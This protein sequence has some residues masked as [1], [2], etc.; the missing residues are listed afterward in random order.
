MTVAPSNHMAAFANKNST[1]VRTERSMAARRM[2]SSLAVALVL[3]VSIDLMRKIIEGWA[4][5]LVQAT[6][7]ALVAEEQVLV[8]LGL[9]SERRQL[10]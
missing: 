3:V 9:E 6:L 2:L 7:W 10:A 4:Q 1:G 5:V 8:R